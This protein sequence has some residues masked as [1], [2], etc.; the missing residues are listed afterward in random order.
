MYTDIQIH[1]CDGFVRFQ[2]VHAV[3]SHK[4][5]LG[6][7]EVGRR[8]ARPGL[9]FFSGCDHP[10]TLEFFGTELSRRGKNAFQHQNSHGVLLGS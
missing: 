7:S 5:W 9:F 4:I 10:F 8:S 1:K 2:F 6:F 3:L